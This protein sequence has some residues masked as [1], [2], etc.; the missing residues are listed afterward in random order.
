MELIFRHYE[1]KTLAK[2]QKLNDKLIKE[3]GVLEQK[4]AVRRQGID[5]LKAALRKTKRA[6]K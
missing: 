2:L 5:L 3:M 4:I 1:S 6:K